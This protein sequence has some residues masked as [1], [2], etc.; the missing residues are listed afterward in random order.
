MKH[1][2]LVAACAFGTAAHP[3]T[4]E[5]QLNQTIENATCGD[6]QNMVTDQSND[7]RLLQG[8]FIGYIIAKTH[9]IE[10]AHQGAIRSILA[11]CMLTPDRDF[12]D[13]I[14]LFTNTD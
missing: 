14:D 5:Y 11:A 10:I 1:I 2:A 3:Q 8:V 7:A 9:G 12:T 6:Y 4:Y 13:T